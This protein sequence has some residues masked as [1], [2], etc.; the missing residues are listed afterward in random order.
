MIGIIKKIL[1]RKYH[2]MLSKKIENGTIAPGETLTV[3]REELTKW[4]EEAVEEINEEQVDKDFTFR[5]LS[6]SVVWISE[7]KIGTRST[8]LSSRS[9]WTPL[10][11]SGYTNHSQKPTRPPN[12]W[13]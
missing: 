12:L 3:S 1:R 4:T 7:S 6:Q 2:K 10:V 13:R 8:Q 11:K 5:K 9:T